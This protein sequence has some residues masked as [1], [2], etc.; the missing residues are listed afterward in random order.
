[1]NLTFSKIV[2]YT[3]KHYTKFQPPFYSPS[4]SLYY[5]SNYT[6]NK[7]YDEKEII[8]LYGAILKVINVQKV[9]DVDN[10]MY[11]TI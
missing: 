8:L 1:M 3:K 7:N 9:Y 2:Q 10:T 5:H 4:D 11:T 6:N